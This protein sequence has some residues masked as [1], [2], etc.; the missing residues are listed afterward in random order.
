MNTGNY[1]LIYKPVIIIKRLIGLGNNQAVLLVSSNI[2]YLVSNTHV[3]L[4]HAAIRSFH[5]AEAVNPGIVGQGTNQTDV[6][7]FRGLNRAH[8]AVMGVMYVTHLEACTL[9]GETARTQGRQ[10]ALVG[11]LCQ[12][13]ML[14]HELG[15]LG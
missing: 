13:V 2:L 4:V 1:A 3:G 9:T 7:T 12:R 11:Q 5:K 8:A 14:V 10:T 6:R 15:Q